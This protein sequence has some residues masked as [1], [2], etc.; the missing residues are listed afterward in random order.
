MSENPLNGLNTILRGKYGN[1]FV[2]ILGVVLAI[3]VI[4]MIGPI[5]K[6]SLV[7]IALYFIFKYF[8]NPKN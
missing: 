3:G 5:I 8:S 6:L 4:R 1:A 2:I 7:L